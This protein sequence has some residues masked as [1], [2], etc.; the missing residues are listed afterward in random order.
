[1]NAHAY[2]KNDLKLMARKFAS[3]QIVPIDDVPELQGLLT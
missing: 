2:G 3:M 1:M